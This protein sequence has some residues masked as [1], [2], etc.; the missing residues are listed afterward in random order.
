MALVIAVIGVFRD[1]LST[2]VIFKVECK[3]WEEAICLKRSRHGGVR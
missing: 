2:G 3:E 1:G